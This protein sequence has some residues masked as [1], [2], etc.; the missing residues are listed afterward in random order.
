VFKKKIGSNGSVEKYKVGLVTK[1]YSHVKG[2]DFG[3]IFSPKIKLTSMRSLLCVPTT[4][5]LSIQQM[6]V[7]TTFLHGNLEV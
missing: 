7:K 6:N 4:F 3:E 2:I 5:D 1:G